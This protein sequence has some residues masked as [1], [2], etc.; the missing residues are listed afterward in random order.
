MQENPFY[1]VDTRRRLNRRWNDVVCLLGRCLRGFWMST[2]QHLTIKRFVKKKLDLFVRVLQDSSK[3]ISYRDFD[4]EPVQ[5]CKVSG[6]LLFRVIAYVIRIVP[7]FSQLSNQMRFSSLAVKTY[8]L[9]NF[10]NVVINN[11]KKYTDILGRILWRKSRKKWYNE[12]LYYQ[13]CYL[14]CKIYWEFTRF[15]SKSWFEEKV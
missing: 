10:V 13:L 4:F 2:L 14:K 1:P 12:K 5:L 6:D 15:Y 9:H 8:K 3:Y 11:K 7:F